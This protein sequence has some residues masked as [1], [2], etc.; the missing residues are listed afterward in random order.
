MLGACRTVLSVQAMLTVRL[1]LWATELQPAVQG[2]V[3][4]RNALDRLPDLPGDSRR[5]SQA[6]ASSV[7]S[8][9]NAFLGYWAPRSLL[10]KSASAQ[11]LAGAPLELLQVLQT[12]LPTVYSAAWRLLQITLPTTEHDRAR[13]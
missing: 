4:L 13:C 9:M 11:S 2:S 8:V 10:D 5:S 1:A 12:N 7:A 3:R 6:G